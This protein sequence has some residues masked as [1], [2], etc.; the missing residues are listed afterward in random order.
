[1]SL[2]TNRITAII[3]AFNAEKYIKETL[4]SLLTQTHPIDKIVIINDGSTDQTSAI[5]KSFSARHEK[6]LYLELDAN[7]GESKAVNVGW[8]NTDTDL[9]A[10]V[11]ADDPQPREWLSDMYKYIVSQPDYLFYY[12]NVITI[13]ES[14]QVLAKRVLP[15]FDKKT[16]INRL[17]CLPGAGTIIAKYRLPASFVPRDELCT[18]P[19]DLIQ[20]MSLSL[21]G[22]GLHATSAWGQ[23]REHSNGLS[24]TMTYF[25]KYSSFFSSI[26]RWIFA[27]RNS[28][29]KFQVQEIRANAFAQSVF[30]LGISRL[31]QKKLINLLTTYFWPNSTNPIFLFKLL[32]VILQN[33]KTIFRRVSRNFWKP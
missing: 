11:N 21:L 29:G 19:S 6:I 18:F 33:Y 1:M 2:N 12:P 9:I 17:I 16:I 23:W 25:A 20:F 10:I 5:S 15:N 28:L 30:F 3:P 13:N 4:E 31:S 22:D 26:N 8:F 27:N 7:Y 14:S 32:I 24:Q